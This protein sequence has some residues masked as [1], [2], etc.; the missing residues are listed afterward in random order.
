MSSKTVI[1]CDLCN[2]ELKENINT[3][4]KVRR[5][6][7]DEYSWIKYYTGHA[8][9]YYDICPECYKKFME[10]IKTIQQQNS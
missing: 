4:I 6:I 8:T 1:T 5:L 9:Q 7:F 3:C 2:V 10:F